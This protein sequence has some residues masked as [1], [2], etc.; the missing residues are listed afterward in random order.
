MQKT[1][2]FPTSK[3]L[4]PSQLIKQVPKMNNH[5][6][7]DPISQNYQNILS[8]RQEMKSKSLRRRQRN[9]NTPSE[10]LKNNILKNRQSKKIMNLKSIT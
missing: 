10:I 7:N 9:K 5:T 4:V 1:D 8:H 2:T 6:L 3:G